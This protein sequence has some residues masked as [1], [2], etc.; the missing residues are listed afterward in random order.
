MA[1]LSNL[2]PS[3]QFQTVTIIPTKVYRNSPLLLILSHPSMVAPTRDL[4]R[5]LNPDSVTLVKILSIFLSSAY[6]V[7]RVTALTVCVSTITLNLFTRPCCELL[8]VVE[9]NIRNTRPSIAMLHGNPPGLG[10]GIMAMTCL[11]CQFPI[12]KL[13]NF[14]ACL[15]TVK[16]HLH[17]QRWAS[18]K[19][20]KCSH[21]FYKPG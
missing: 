7:F 21:A 6:F 17:P 9:W 8:N 10:H 1:N 2:M 20:N 5:F 3:A 12:L 16:S 19:S 15:K 18:N 14:H 4:S 11:F 13:K